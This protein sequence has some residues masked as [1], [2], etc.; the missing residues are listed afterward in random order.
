MDQPTFITR[1]V[2]WFLNLFGIEAQTT[3]QQPGSGAPTPVTRKVSLIIYNPTIPSAGGQPLTSVMNWNDPD[4]LAAG[5]IADLRDISHGYINYEIA[6]RIE[7]DAFPVK[8]D[9]FRYTGDEYVTCMRAGQGFHMPDAVDY[10]EVLRQNDLIARVSS[11]KIDEVWTISFPYAGF[12][13]SRMAG[14]G[15]FWCNAPALEG[16]ESA[17]RRFVIMAFNYERGVG[18]M[19]ESFGHRAESIL[20]HVYRN[21][22]DSQNLWKRFSLYDKVAPRR[23]EVGIVHFAPNSQSDYDWGN[24]SPVL[25]RCRTWLNFPNLSGDPV[26]LNCAEWGGGDIRAHHRWWFKLMPHISG[27]AA[28]ISYNWWEYIVDP[29]RAR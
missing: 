15:A 10:A 21:V 8:E 18:E 26:M 23:A 11:G 19:L 5:L 7:V 28:G 3:S 9:G 13:E 14:P 25:T 24:P 16:F 2:N 1:M 20:S 4:R 6:E 12:Y 22:P 17:G 27:Q 29:N